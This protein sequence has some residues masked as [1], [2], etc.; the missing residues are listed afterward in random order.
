VNQDKLAKENGTALV[1]KSWAD[2]TDPR[3]RE[4]IVMPNPYTSGTGYMVVSGWMQMQPFGERAGWAYIDRLHENIASYTSSGSE[5]CELV[6]DDNNPRIAIGIAANI[7]PSDSKP[8][9][10]VTVYPK[11][12]SGWEMDA[13]ALVR[14][15]EISDGAL[16]FLAWAISQE[17]MEEYAQFRSGL[18][19]RAF[20]PNQTCFK[21]FDE[22][23]M[24]PHRFLWASAN[25]ERIT[26][27]WLS[28]YGNES[29]R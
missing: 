17:A 22:E 3:Y 4:Q 26:E 27:Q 25:F 15:D 1:P 12:G 24:T 19:Y 18:A 28:R 6:A 7:C 2:L 9:N 21:D 11:E 20:E 23:P 10:L 5:P 13:V 29:D 16:A 8:S 14:K